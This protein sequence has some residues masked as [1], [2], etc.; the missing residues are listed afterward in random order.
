MTVIDETPVRTQ[1]GLNA[2][3]CGHLILMTREHY[4][5]CKETGRSWFCTVCGCGRAFTGKTTVEQLRGELAAAK[6][7]EE[8]EKARRRDAEEGLRQQREA[9]RK[10]QKSKERLKKRIKNGVCP[11]CHRT[12]SQLARHM[13]TKHP[14]FAV[15]GEAPR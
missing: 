9:L 13:K 2:N 10:E 11:C 14:D 3:G 4:D 8:T 5:A 12:V 1:I 6:Q 7:R 15:N